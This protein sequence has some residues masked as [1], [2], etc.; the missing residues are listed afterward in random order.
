MSDIN[1]NAVPFDELIDP[2]GQVLEYASGPNQ[3][4]LFTVVRPWDDEPGLWA[5]FEKGAR[6]PLRPGT[7][8][9][10]RGRAKADDSNTI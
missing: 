5:E 2:I 7:M 10:V 9:I 4:K 8:V 3:G 1:T 6:L